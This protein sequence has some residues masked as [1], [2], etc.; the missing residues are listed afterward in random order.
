MYVRSGYTQ[1]TH[2]KEN[3]M[4]S[5]KE[6]RELKSKEVND[7]PIFFAFSNEQLKE[8]MEKRGLKDDEYDKIYRL[9]IAGGFYLR[10][11]AEIIRAYFSKENELPKLL[12]NKRF[13]YQAFNYE[14]DNHEYAINYEGDYDVI[15]CFFKCEYAYEK[16]YKDYL[17]ECDREDL[18]ETYAKA[19]AAHFKRAQK[20]F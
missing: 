11:D 17:K 18:I 10:A 2:R 4:I 1:R 9:P 14:M 15:S 7:L 19:R 20:W 16:D 13:A 6:Y 8:Q 5:Y 3:Q 12:N